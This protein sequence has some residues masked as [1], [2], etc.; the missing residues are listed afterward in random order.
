MIRCEAAER[1]RK[2]LSEEIMKVG[3]FYASATQ[4][5]PERQET[6]LWVDK[7]IE[8]MG[9]ATKAISEE[10][11][12]REQTASGMGQWLREEM[13]RLQEEQ[14]KCSQQQLQQREQFVQAM[15]ELV[16]HAH[17]D[18]QQALA[19]NLEFWEGLGKTK[20]KEEKEQLAKL[21][22][23]LA[24]ETQNHQKEVS[25]LQARLEE[26]ERE[27]RAMMV[28]LQE[29]RG[30]HEARERESRQEKEQLRIVVSGLL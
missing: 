9:A 17:Q 24:A 26:C 1:E 28:G 5:Q 15:K 29:M 25:Q 21:Q 18:Y 8:F 14:D 22:A 23:Q 11:H 20:S 27:R 16:A 13:R 12:Q 10:A 30:L 19:S 2:V 4:R 6:L 7:L 3:K